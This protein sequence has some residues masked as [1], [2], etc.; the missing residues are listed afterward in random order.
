MFTFRKHNRILS[1]PEFERVLNASVKVV[2]PLL[3]VMAQPAETQRLGIIA[4]KKV[5]NAVARNTVK[6]WI[7]ESYR[8]APPT[9]E[10]KL[11]VV[12][13]ARPAAH[14]ADFAAVQD[15]LASCFARLS[16]RIELK[17]REVSC[18]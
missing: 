17:K 1:R 12:V 11:D 6:R 14:A 9:F 15:A 2:D 5:G 3:V 13:I 4:S 18:A 10:Q 8:L 7:R 16:R